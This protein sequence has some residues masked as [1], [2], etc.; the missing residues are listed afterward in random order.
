MISFIARGKTSDEATD[1]I[2]NNQLPKLVKLIQS[3]EL[4]VDNIDV[5]CEKG[6]FSVKQTELIFIK[7]N[8]LHNFNINFHSDELYPLNS[9]EVEKIGTKIDK[10]LLFAAHFLI[11][12]GS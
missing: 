7:S 12:D 3:K 6:V 4:D 5:F 10:I 9:V 11:I 2:I 1:D 8:S